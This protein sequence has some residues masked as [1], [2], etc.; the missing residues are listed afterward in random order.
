MALES[1][2]VHVEAD[3][4]ELAPGGDGVAIVELGGERRAVFARGTCPGERAA[5]EVDTARRPARG[6]VL[7][8]LRRSADRVDPACRWALRCGG[9]DW[10]HLAP[11][12]QARFHEELVRRALPEPWRATPITA[13]SAGAALGYRTR[14]RLHARASGG[15][16]IVGMNEIASHQPVEVDACVV[17]EPALEAA[18][19]RVGPLLDGA[20]GRGE[21]QIALGALVESGDARRPVLELRWSGALAG[22]VYARME[23]AVAA[24]DWAGARIFAGETTRP[25]VIGDPTPWMQGADGRPLRLPPGGFAQASEQANAELARRVAELADATNARRAIELFAGAGN[26]SVLLARGRQLVTVESDRPAC[27]AARANLAVRG[28]SARVVEGDAET[29]PLG[30]NI[31]LVVLDPPR[32]GA[33][34]ATAALLQRPPKHIVYVACDPQTLGRDLASLAPRFAPRAIETFEMFPGTSHV[35]TVVALTRSR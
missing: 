2:D 11:D 17:L 25:A 19:R 6:R 33:R 20:H 26:L 8:I 24:R 7:Q 9:C 31:D 28:L 3:I 14:A 23:R 4:S 29:T 18:R 21:A 16:A 34:G 35:E 15:R 10:M 12:A 1:S 32:T 13:R 30:G 22:E 27:D 5:L